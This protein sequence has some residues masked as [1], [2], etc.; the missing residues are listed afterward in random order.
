MLIYCHPGKHQFA[1]RGLLRNAELINAS[2]QVR[3]R[4]LK[5]EIDNASLQPR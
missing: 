1:I 5:P 3:I 2:T 4:T